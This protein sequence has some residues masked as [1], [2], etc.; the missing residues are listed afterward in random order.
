MSFTEV[1]PEEAFKILA[2]DPEAVYV[3]VRS[4]PEFA[5]EHP[6]GAI[7]IPI[8]HQGASGNMEPNPDFAEVA[9]AVL[10]KEKKIVMGCLRGGR[11]MKA[12]MILAGEGYDQLYNVLGGFGGAV[13]PVTGMVSQKGWKDSELPTSQENGEG[14]GYESLKSKAG[15]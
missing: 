12:C 6:E 11:G 1:T 15:L 2:E 7:N 10:P 9:S 8:L 5:Q 4:I 13:D 14:V 3:D